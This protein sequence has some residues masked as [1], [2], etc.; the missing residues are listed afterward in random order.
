MS[1]PSLAFASEVRGKRALGLTGLR[2]KAGSEA[3]HGQQLTRVEVPCADHVTVRLAFCAL[4]DLWVQWIC[5]VV[6]ATFPYQDEPRERRAPDGPRDGNELADLRSAS[7]P[8][9]AVV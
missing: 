3:V 5:G 4:I 8:A 1:P 7:A 2:G 6:A 9:S